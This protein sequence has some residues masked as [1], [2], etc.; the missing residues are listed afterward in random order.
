VWNIA[1]DSIVFVDDSELELA[2]VSARWPAATCLRFPRESDAQ[3]YA[4]L[5]RLRGLFGK[6][7]ISADDGLRT[8]SLRNAQLFHQRVASSTAPSDEFLSDLGAELVLSFAK[9]PLYPRALELI[10]K[11]NQFNLNGRRYTEGEWL[12]FVADP[13]SFLVIVGYTDKFG[14][15]G[16]IGVVAGRRRQ[17]DV[18]ID[19]WVLS[20]RAF[21]RRIEH[22]VLKAVFARFGAQVVTLDFQATAKNG[23]MRAYLS[24]ICG[25][26]PT[27]PL[28]LT[29]SVFEARCP[30]LYHRVKEIP[31]D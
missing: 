28:A 25:L 21:S 26:E 8:E 7:S 27:G 1:P 12:A 18:S 6:A 5:E 22:A 19:T 13:T 14:P 24:E 15:L 9:Q 31:N 3:V 4:L 11:T 17:N 30:P 16:T 29:R 10:N 2:E 20:C 23:P